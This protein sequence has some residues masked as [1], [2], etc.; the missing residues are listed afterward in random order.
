[1]ERIVEVE[2]IDGIVRRF[3]SQVVAGRVK[4]LV[5]VTEQECEETKRL[6]QKCHDVTDAHAPTTSAIPTPDD[7][8][9][10]ISDTRQLIATIKDRKKKNKETAGKP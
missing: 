10:D 2:L 3:E 5:G 9:Q 8:K 1:M 6:L 7:L 4:S